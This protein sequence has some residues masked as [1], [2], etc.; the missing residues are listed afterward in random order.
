MPHAFT[1]EKLFADNSDRPQRNN[2]W[3][4]PPTMRSSSF[5]D[6]PGLTWCFG[7]IEN[8][9]VTKHSFGRRLFSKIPPDA[10]TCSDTMSVESFV[11]IVDDDPAFAE[12]LST[13]ITSMGARTKTFTSADDYLDQFDPQVPGC[14]ILDVRMQ[15]TSGLVLQEQLSK[16]PLSP[17][18]IIMTGHAE[19]PTA[20]RAMRMGAV[21]FLQKTFSETELFE[22]VQ[23]ALTQDARTRHEYYRKEAIE[24]RFSQLTPPERSVLN[25]V[26]QGEAN[27][28]IAASLGVS[29]RTVEDRRA[30]IMQK[31]EVESLADLV[32][33]S[34]E[35]GV[36]T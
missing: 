33:V 30:R 12:S 1:R 36:Q 29:R 35:A 15:R 34:M 28:S 23:R 9:N 3:T 2:R 20:L 4:F 17:A 6:S 18:I 13:L 10:P 5:D 14:L 7:V 24:R 27:K 16:L 21:D 25:Q 19:V 8:E 32:R 22:A 11:F 31:L 26:L